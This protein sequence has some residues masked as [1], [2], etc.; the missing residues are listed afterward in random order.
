MPASFKMFLKILFRKLNYLFLSLIL[1]VG[2]LYFLMISMPGKSPKTFDENSLTMTKEFEQTRGNLAYFVNTLSLTIGERNSSRY[3]TL[4]ETAEWIQK[5]FK[6]MGYPIKRQ[7]YEVNSK[8]YENLEVQILGSEKENVIVGA[9]Y[10]SAVGSLGA[11][12][13]AT[14]VAALLNLAQEFR[15]KQ[16]L[17]TLRFV[18]FVNEE[19]PFFDTENMGSLV[20]AQKAWLNDEKIKAMV[21]LEGLGYFS[22]EKGSQKYPKPLSFFYPS[23]GNFIAFVGNISSRGLVHNA[24]SH[25]R[26]IS[27]LPSQGIAAFE[28]IPGVNM[29]D[30]ASFWKHGYEAIMI[31][32]TAFYRNPYYHSRQDKPDKIDFL[33]F[34]RLVLDLEK[35]IERICGIRKQA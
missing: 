4:Q 11:D 8:K 5:N 18:A 12:D 17:C 34:T 16:T 28:S 29:S 24:I 32:D 3:K 20:Y 9:H 14:G 25:F 19:P 27:V 15:R 35:V 31:T 33:R 23:T 22:N 21:S 10:D 13:N 26:K 7:V 6:K 1:L 2:G 30:H